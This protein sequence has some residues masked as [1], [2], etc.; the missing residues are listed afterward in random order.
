MTSAKGASA[1][2]GSATGATTPFATVNVSPF[3]WYVSRSLRLPRSFR[4]FSCSDTWISEGCRRGTRA[5]PASVRCPRDISRVCPRD[6]THRDVPPRD[7]PNLDRYA[8]PGR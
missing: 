2:P 3:L 8:R 4:V 5:A 1:Q 7:A 6:V